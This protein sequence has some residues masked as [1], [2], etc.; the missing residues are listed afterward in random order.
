[1]AGRPA[2]ELAAAV[3]DVENDVAWWDNVPDAWRDVRSGMPHAEVV[4]RHGWMYRHAEHEIGR[5][6][7]AAIV[8]GWPHF[9]EEA[10]MRAQMFKV[11]SGLTVGGDEREPPFSTARTRPPADVATRP[12]GHSIPTEHADAISRQRVLMF[13]DAAL[14]TWASTG[15]TSDALRSVRQAVEE[16]PA[17]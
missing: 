16:E 12:A 13:I 5:G 4:R 14:F 10:G 11:D 8:R 3:E 6:R 17:L 15:L 7:R 2:G 1:M 9:S